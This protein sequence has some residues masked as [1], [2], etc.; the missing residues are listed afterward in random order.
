MRN[1]LFGVFCLAT[2]LVGSGCAVEKASNRGRSPKITF[3]LES[4]TLP[5][6]NK[7]KFIGR[8]VAPDGNSVEISKPWLRIAASKLL[9]EDAKGREFAVVPDRKYFLE[10]ELLEEVVLGDQEVSFV[11]QIAPRM[12]AGTYIWTLDASLMPPSDNRNQDPI[13]V[14]GSGVVNVSAKP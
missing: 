14:N 5:T 11:F 1:N 6:E 7:V 3:T 10:G 13:S 2:S 8:F 4:A 12:S 9:L